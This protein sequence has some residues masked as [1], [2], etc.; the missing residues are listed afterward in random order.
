MGDTVVGVDGFF[1]N[2]FGRTLEVIDAASD[3]EELLYGIHCALPNVFDSGSLWHRD[4]N[5]VSP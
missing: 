5:S 1:H 2:P 3:V 4:E